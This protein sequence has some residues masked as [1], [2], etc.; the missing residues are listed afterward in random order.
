[1][2]ILV[3]NT[4]QMKEAIDMKEAIRANEIA[5]KNYSAGKAD[6]PLR[7]NLDIEKY[8]GKS[9][10]MPG[11]LEDED[12]LGVKI[13]SVYPDNIQKGLTSVPSLMLL[14]DAETGFPKCM[15]NGTYLTQLRTGALAGLG[16]E[17]LSREDSKIFTL[18]GTGGQAE[19]QLEAVLAVRDIEKV[20]V[21]GINEEKCLEFVEKV[22]LK[23]EDK[24]NVKIEK[25]NNLEQAIKESDIIT[26][27]TTSKTPTFNGEWVKKGTHINGVGSYTPDMI[28]IDG[29]LILKADKVYC[30]TKDAIVESGDFVNI[31]KNEGYKKENIDGELGELAVNK[32][33]GRVS[34]E[35]ITFFKT[36]GNAVLDI[37]VAKKIYDFA[38]EKSIGETISI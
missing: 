38:I 24:Y 31:I 26:S 16:T 2:E 7:T 6:I 30:D 11:Y 19:Q 5:L 1:M 33:A 27:V 37:M 3:L 18:I 20:N 25:C 12:A 10:Y 4:E 29:K 32:S 23:F 36:T 17:L 14:V 34:D 21:F 28:E 9:L 13:V 35:D 15:M 22:S 8:D